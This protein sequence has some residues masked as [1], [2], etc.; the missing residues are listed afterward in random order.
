MAIRKLISNSGQSINFTVNSYRALLLIEF[1]DGTSSCIYLDNPKEDE[2]EKLKNIQAITKIKY[3]GGQGI[4]DNIKKHEFKWPDFERIVVSEEDLEAIYFPSQNRVRMPKKV[5]KTKLSVIRSN[6]NAA[7]E[8]S[9]KDVSSS[10]ATEQEK[11]YK[12]LIIEDSLPIQKILKKIISGSNRLEV[13]DVAANPHQAMEI[14]DKQKPDLITLDIHMPEMNGVDFLKGYLKGKKIPTVMISSVNI[15]EGPLV[16]DALANGAITYIKKPSLEKMDESK[17][18][19]ISKLE[20]IASNTK[21]MNFT[22][23]LKASTGFNDSRGIIVIGS[24]TGGT[25][26][27]QEILQALPDQIPPILIVQHIP[28]VFSKA[29]ADRLDTLCKFTVKEADE[30]EFV[31]K[32]TVYIAPGGKQMKIVNRGKEKMIKLTDDPP[33]NRFKPS[34]DYFFNSVDKLEE[35]LIVGVILTGMGKDGAKGLLKLR[36]KGSTTIAQDEE[37]SIVFGMPREAIEIG[38]AENIVSLKNM[39]DALVSNYNKKLRDV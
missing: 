32:N 21:D 30:D 7:V 25:Q 1:F 11:F 29:L 26:A 27:L 2:Y 19:I 9:H 37:S 38:A 4:L 34:V 6:E 36:E 22:H 18:E 39:A 24:S 17:E 23:A 14:I 16:M 10:S 15:N 28:A 8:D 31:K 12:V 13:M 33:M 35:K 3:L 5:Q 20:T